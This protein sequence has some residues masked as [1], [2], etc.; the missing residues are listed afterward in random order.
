MSPDNTHVRDA[1][2]YCL[3]GIDKNHFVFFF[4]GADSVTVDLSG[5]PAS[6][7]VIAVDTNAD[8]KEIDKGKLMASVHTIR[9]GRTSDW[10]LAIGDFVAP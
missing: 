10:V 5:M 2:G 3:V 9:L 8:Y 6:Q 7:Q 1:E 4:E